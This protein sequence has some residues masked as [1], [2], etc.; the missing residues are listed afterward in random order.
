MP[1]PKNRR[2]TWRTAKKQ[3]ILV[4]MKTHN[5]R[6][7][8][9]LMV[10]PF[11]L[12]ATMGNSTAQQVIETEPL[13]PF[14]ALDIDG[15]IRIELI[16]A[17]ENQMQIIL[18][19]IDSKNISWRVKD[20]TLSIKTR[21]GLVNKRAYADIKLFYREISR[22][23][24][25]G[26]E[27]TTKYPLLCASLYLGAESSVGRMDLI[28]ECNDI[29]I[30]TSGG[31]TVK[32]NGI[33]E[34]ASYE[35]KLGSHIECLGLTASHV[36]ADVSGKAEIQLHANELLDARAVTGGNI[37]FK[38]EPVT[39]YIKKSTMGGVESVNNL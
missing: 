22:I 25:I 29:T 32:V 15:P 14:T 23:T 31:N 5:T 10:L 12:L 28:V 2:H 21:K 33:T 39:L 34:Y 30:H 13:A 35:A 18:W 6:F 8:I 38:G 4:I 20:H 1:A 26:G 7:L 3:L 24:T 27:V 9:R 16:P 37:F 36:T 11:L 17:D 19:D